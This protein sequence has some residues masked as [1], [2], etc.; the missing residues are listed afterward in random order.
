[1]SNDKRVFPRIEVKRKVSLADES[2][3]GLA[4]I[5]DVSVGGICLLSE[6]EFPESAHFYVMF[7]GCTKFQETE[8]EAESLRCFPTGDPD[9]PYRVAAMYVDPDAE[10]INDL[11]SL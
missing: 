10:Y 2:S 7:P 11:N 1:M 3:L 4:E 9:Y 5:I 6:E 8:I